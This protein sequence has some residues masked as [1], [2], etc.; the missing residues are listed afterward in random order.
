MIIEYAQLEVAPDNA[1]AF[2]AAVAKAAPLFRAAAGCK[3]MKLERLVEHPGR[4][5]LV[6]KWTSLDD[7]MVG[8]RQSA[9]FA[10]WRALTGPYFVAAPEVLHGELVGNFF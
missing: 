6:V 8:F 9:A 1:A 4:Y 3:G 2:E 10:E 5:L 7:H